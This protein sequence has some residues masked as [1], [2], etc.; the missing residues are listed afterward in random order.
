MALLAPKLG[1]P[2]ANWTRQLRIRADW[3]KGHR[4]NELEKNNNNPEKKITNLKKG[5]ICIHCITR[6]VTRIEKKTK[7]TLPLT[8]F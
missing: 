5:M 4:G 7:K 3:G 8:V 1:K 6:R 2:Q